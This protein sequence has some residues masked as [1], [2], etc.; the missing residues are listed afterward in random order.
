MQA[1]LLLWIGTPREDMSLQLEE[2]ETVVS[3]VGALVKLKLGVM[4]RYLYNESNLSFLRQCVFVNCVML[5]LS[6]CGILKV[7]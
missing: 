4:L 5:R 1:K 7:D 3:K 2:D 6:Q